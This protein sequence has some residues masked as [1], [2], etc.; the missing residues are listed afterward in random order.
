MPLDQ[1]A[2]SLLALAG[3]LALILLGQ[4]LLKP[5]G[6]LRPSLSGRLR[7]VESVAIDPRRRLVLAQWDGRD[8]LLLTGGGCDLLIHAPAAGDNS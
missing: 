8:V 4:K 5:G 3:V 6:R 1:L 2:A 7:V